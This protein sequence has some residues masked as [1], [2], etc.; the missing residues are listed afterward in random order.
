MLQLLWIGFETSYEDRI[1][2]RGLAQVTEMKFH[3]FSSQFILQTGSKV[4]FSVQT[5]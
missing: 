3:S 1:H 5:F 4:C 2:K